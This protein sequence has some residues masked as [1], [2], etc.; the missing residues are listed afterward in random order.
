VDKIIERLRK[1]CEEIEAARMADEEA[2]NA[3]LENA[4][5]CRSSIGGRCK[6]QN[7]RAPDG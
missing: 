7:S 3:L 4:N 1:T 6:P 5:A 2:K